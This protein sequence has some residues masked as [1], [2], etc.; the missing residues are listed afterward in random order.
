M[1][2][3]LP[4][5]LDMASGRRGVQPLDSAA[6]QQ[7]VGNLPPGWEWDSPIP[8]ENRAGR[9]PFTRQK[10]V[11]TRAG[12]TLKP[13]LVKSY[14]QN[15]AA[16][17]GAINFAL[18]TAGGTVVL[19]NP[20]VPGDLDGNRLGRRINMLNI[21][22]KGL[23]TPVLGTA[24]TTDSSNMYAIVYDR[25]PNAVAATYQNIFTDVAGNAT[26]TALTPE[27]PNFEGRF[28]VL[29]RVNLNLPFFTTGGTGAND[30][31]TMWWRDSI[32]SSTNIKMKIN[33]RELLT[34][35]NATGGATAASIN[36]GALYLVVA[37]LGNWQIL[38]CGWIIE[39]VDSR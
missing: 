8:G 1:L 29:K 39:Y 25:F 20:I 5:A 33:L 18:G 31:G 14:Y 11:L 2:F 7:T 23:I 21:R 32:S 38:G 9:V 30:A 24:V 27:N 19:L 15:G 16:T 36:T 12:G 37:G 28:L 35:Y 4:A 6:Y 26:Q 22:F 13:S 3:E 34:V 10:K 17:P